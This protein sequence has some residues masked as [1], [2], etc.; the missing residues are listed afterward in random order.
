ML[1][2]G[3]LERMWKESVKSFVWKAE[4]NRSGEIRTLALP[5][6]EQEGYLITTL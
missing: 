4:R 6:K 1:V 2:K 3:E 5:N